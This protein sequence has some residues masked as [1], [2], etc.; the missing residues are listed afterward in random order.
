MED[1]KITNFQKI[2]DIYNYVGWDYF[3]WN[4]PDK[5]KVK[6]S[7]FA[8]K[9]KQHSLKINVHDSPGNY[10]DWNFLIRLA[11]RCNYAFI[12]SPYKIDNSLDELYQFVNRFNK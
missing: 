12:R 3:G 4:H 2:R 7:Y 10:P 11:N 1:K 9:G 8:A 6:G 5:L